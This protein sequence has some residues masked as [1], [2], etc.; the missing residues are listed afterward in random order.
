MPQAAE[1]TVDMSMQTD[2][3]YVRTLAANGLSTGRL[4]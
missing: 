2:V 1:R 3:Q 4:E